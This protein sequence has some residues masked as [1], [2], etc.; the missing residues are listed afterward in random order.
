MRKKPLF[1]ANVCHKSLEGLTVFCL[2]ME[3]IDRV[4]W[5]TNRLL[6]S[7]GWYWIEWCISHGVRVGLK[8]SPILIPVFWGLT[9]LF[10]D[11]NVSLWVRQQFL[12][13][14]WVQ[15]K[16]FYIFF[17]RK[18]LNRKWILKNRLNFFYWLGFFFEDRLINDLWF[19]YVLSCLWRS[20]TTYQM[21]RDYWKKTENQL[22]VCL[23]K[24]FCSFGPKFLKPWNKSNDAKRNVWSLH[25][26]LRPDLG[27]DKIKFFFFDSNSHFSPTLSISL[28]LS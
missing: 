16:V 23:L 26:K 5:T 19:F 10:A 8:T 1:F 6:M 12:C 27:S 25:W 17:W 7:T 13:Q 24:Y 22:T 11:Q 2:F 14:N 9:S 4:V 18:L 21:I 20:S 28:S 15:R 3:K